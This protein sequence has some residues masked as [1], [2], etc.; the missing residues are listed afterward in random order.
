MTIATARLPGLIITSLISPSSHFDSYCFSIY[1]N[2]DWLPPV[3][4]VQHRNYAPAC[5]QIP[6]VS[7]K[8]SDDGEE[9]G[10]LT[11]PEHLSQEP[12]YIHD[13]RSDTSTN[14]DLTHIP[15]NDV[16]I[17]MDTE[18]LVGEATEMMDMAAES[19]IT[20]FSP[21]E[22]ALQAWR[23]LSATNQSHDLKSVCT[24]PTVDTNDSLDCRV[25]FKAW[26]I[27]TK[28]STVCF[29]TLVCLKVLDR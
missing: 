12:H 7:P 17:T 28:Y 5:H 14:S 8:C 2:H 13:E 20:I 25:H 22:N 1:H 29:D 4:P 19:K 27:S 15:E 9:S 11:G 21:T 10:A 16:S 6:L 23:T 18:E 3:L 24:E 26:Q